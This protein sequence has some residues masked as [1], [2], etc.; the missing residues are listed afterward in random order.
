MRFFELESQLAVGAGT[1]AT[2]QGALPQNGLFSGL[3]GAAR[4]PASH[5]SLQALAPTETVAPLSLSPSERQAKAGDKTL[6]SH[7]APDTGTCPCTVYRDRGS[8]VPTP[9]SLNPA[10]VGSVFVIY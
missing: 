1:R 8:S 7:S 9:L 10:I 4:R 2:L 5:L 6:D 3:V